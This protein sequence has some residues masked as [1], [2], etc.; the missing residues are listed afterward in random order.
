MTLG[1]DQ[2]NVIRSLIDTSFAKEHPN[3]RVELKLTAG[4]VLLK[5][6]LA[7]IGPDVALNVDSSLPVNYALRNAVL[8]LSGF[9]Y[10][11]NEDGSLNL[12]HYKLNFAETFD[13]EY[14][15]DTY[16]FT[17]ENEI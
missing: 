2:A 9:I 6:T 12:R 16:T 11:L 5:A 7:G 10:E 13:D 4:D 3:I 15:D 17:D 1:R 8:D 14:R